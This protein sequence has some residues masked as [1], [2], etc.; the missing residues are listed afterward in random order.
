[1]DAAIER[2]FSIGMG[3]RASVFGAIESADKFN[4][5]SA[6]AIPSGPDTVGVV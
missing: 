3:D 6:D 5:L 2:K 4:I 1:M